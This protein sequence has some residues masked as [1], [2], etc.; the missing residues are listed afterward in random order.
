M[1][2]HEA[3]EQIG[4][5]IAAHGQHVYVVAGGPNPRFAYTIG[6][7]PDIGFEIVLAGSSFFSAAECGEIIEMTATTLRKDPA[8][9]KLQIE[10]GSWG[11][12]SLCEVDESWSRK[13]ALGAFDY[14][15]ASSI[16]VVQIV[17]DRDHWTVD[18]PNL[19]KKWDA[20]TEPVWQWL[21]NPWKYAVPSKSVAATNLDALRG[22]PITEA[23]R[24]EED[25]WELFAGAG[26]DVSPDDIRLVPLGTLLGADSSI[27]A[28]TGL[29]IERGLWRDPVEQEWHSWGSQ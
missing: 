4:A 21:G 25:Q 15:N 27:E 7:S 17:P 14:Y 16:P 12:F 26:P 23:M 10:S 24:W 8:G 22:Q 28:V 20:T 19:G 3:L 5:N 18:V 29:T 9:R 1:T 13:L 2:K 11:S 6:L